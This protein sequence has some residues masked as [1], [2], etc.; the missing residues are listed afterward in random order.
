MHNEMNNAIFDMNALR[1][2]NETPFALHRVLIYASADFYHH[3]QLAFYVFIRQF[4]IV[5][6]TP[7]YVPFE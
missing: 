5:I 1:K 3:I 4:F 2:K 6:Y 7:F